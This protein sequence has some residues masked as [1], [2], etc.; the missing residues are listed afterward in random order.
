MKFVNVPASV[1]AAYAAVPRVSSRISSGILRALVL[2][3][4][5]AAA[6]LASAQVQRTFVNLGFEQPSAGS[7][8]C[9][10]QVADAQVPGWT[11]NHPSQAGASCAPSIAAQTGPL[12]EIWANTFNGVNAR[13]GTQFAELNAEAASRIYQNVCLAAGEPIDWRFSHR[14]RQSATTNDVTEFRVGSSTGT[15]RVVRAGTQSDGG[16]GVVTCYA[17]DGGVNTNTCTSALATFGW[18]DYSGHFTWQGSTGVQAI[19]FEAVSAAG[20]ATIGNFIDDIQVTLRPFVELSTASVSLRENATSGWPMLRVVGTVPAGGIVVP[21]TVQG[22]GTAVRGSDFATTGGSDTF[23]VTIPAGVYDGNSVALPLA[24]I[25]DTLIEDNEFVDIA[26]TASPT[27]YVLSSTQV[28]GAAAILSARVTLLDNDV[29]LGV[30]LDAP[31]SVRDGAALTYTATY[32]NRT[33]RATAGDA[34]A[35][36]ATVSVSSTT[37]AGLTI[38]GWTCAASGGARCPGGAPNASVTGSGP[39]AGALLLPG[40]AGAAGGEVTFTVGATVTPNHCSAIGLSASLAAPTGFSEA[41]GAQPGFTTPAPN[42]SSDNTASR[43][44]SVTCNSAPV[45]QAASV[46]VTNTTTVAITLGAIDADGD[47]L[48]Y[49]VTTPPAHGTL[50][51]TAPALTYTPASGYVGSDTFAFTANDGTATSAPATISV[52]VTAA[53]RAPAFTG[54]APTSVDEGATYTFANPV[55]DPDS[56]DTQNHSRLNGPDDLAVSASTGAIGWPANAAIVGSNRAPNT[57]CYGGGTTVSAVPLMADV[58]AIVDESG[59]MIGEHA[60]TAD[61]AIPFHAYLTANGIGAGGDAN[62]YGLMG[63]NEAPRVIPVGG[64]LMGNHLDFLE[65][66]SHYVIPEFGGTEDGW[67]AIHGALMQYPLRENSSR[68]V[69]LITDEDRD[70]ANVSLS[71]AS[72]LAELQTYK[73]ALTAVVNARFQCGDASVALGLGPDGLG[74]KA[75]GGGGY[76]TCTNASAVSGDG[77]TIADYVNLALATG[78]TAWDIELLRDGGHMAESFTSAL[79]AA[80]VREILT[81]EPTAAQAD[82]YVHDLRLVEGANDVEVIIG[83]RGLAAVTQAFTV[84]FAADGNPF[85]QVDVASLANG[86]TVTRRVPWTGGNPAQISATIS[87]PGTIDC[88]ADNASL[89]AVVARV[90]VTDAGGLADERQFSIGVADVNAA[91]SIGSTAP[92]GVVPGDRYVYAVQA[93]DPDRGDALEYTLTTAPSGMTIDRLTG[94]I[95]FAPTSNQSGSHAVTV[96]VADLAGLYATQSYSLSVGAGRVLPRFTSLPNRRAVQGQTYTYAPTVSAAPDAVLSFTRVEGPSGMQVDAT[97]GAVSWGVPGDFAGKSARVALRVNDQFGGFHLQFFTLLGDK[98]NEPPVFT[99]QPPT[100]I[101][102][103]GD[104]V[105]PTRSS[106]INL[107]ET[108]TWSAPLKPTGAA[109]TTTPANPAPGTWGRLTWPLTSQTPVAP[110]GLDLQNPWCSIVPASVRAFQP[111]V[112]WRQS[113]NGTSSQPLVGPLTDTDG[114]GVLNTNDR[115]AAVSVAGLGGPRLRAHDAYTGDILWTYTGG[116]ADYEV[117]PAMADLEGRGQVTILYLDTTRRLVALNGDGTLRWTSS[118]QAGNY[119]FYTNAISLADLDRD[120][121]AEILIGPAVFSANGTLRWQYPSPTY[122]YSRAVALDLDGDGVQEVL[123]RSEARSATGT[124][125]W[126]TPSALANETVQHSQLAP[127]PV[128]GGAQLGVVVSEQTTAGYRLSLLRSDGTAIWRLT[129]QTI[130]DRVGAPLVADFIAEEPGYEIY[131]AAMEKL[132]SSQD[133]RVIWSLKGTQGARRYSGATAAALDGDNDGFLEIYSPSWDGLNRVDARTGV[134]TARVGSYSYQFQ[135]AGPVPTFADPRGDGQGRLWLGEGGYAA[136]FTPAIGNWA[137]GARVVHQQAYAADRIGEDMR[138]RVAMPG[139]LPA[140]L[141]VYGAPNPA[142]TPTQYQSDLRAFGPYIQGTSGEITLRADVRNRGTLASQPYA[143]AFYRG[144]SAIQA[145]RIGRVELPAL[146]VGTT[147][148]ASLPGLEPSALGSGPLFAAIEPASNENECA[149]GNNT[150]GGWAFQVA[151]TDNEAATTTQTWAAGFVQA[152]GVAP[153]FTTTGPTTGNEQQPYRYD[154]VAT[155]PYAGDA[156]TYELAFGPPGMV[157]D[158]RRGTVEWTPAWGQTGWWQFTIRATNLAGSYTQQQTWVNVTPSSAPNTAPAFTSTAP[159]SAIVGVTYDY[160][161]QAADAEGHVIT[162]ALNTAPTGMTIEAATGRVRWTPSATATN[163]PVTVKATDARGA[164][165]TQS[166]TLN[167]YPGANRAPVITSTPGYTAAPASAYAYTVTATDADNDTLTTTWLTV[168]GG[169]TTT[170]ATVNW[171]PQTAQVGEHTF[172]LEV[173]DGRGG[174]AS[175][176]WVVFV[177]DAATNG[178]PSLSGTPGTNATIAQSYTYAPSATDPDNDTLAWRLAR[179]PAGMTIS[180]STGAIAWTPVRAQVGTHAV[181]IE[182]SDGHGGGAWQDY[183]ITAAIDPQNPPPNTAPVIDSEPPTAAKIG[184]AYRYDVL[185]HDDDGETLY[186]S[187]QQ[188]PAGMTIASGTGRID[189][190]AA[191]TGTVEV[192]VRVADTAGSWAEQSWELT[193]GESGAMS[194]NLLVAPNVVLPNQNVNVKLVPLRDAGPLTGTLTLDGQAVALDAELEAVV[195]AAAPGYHTLSASLNDGVETAVAAAQFFVLDPSQA[196]APRV[197]LTAPEDTA[198]ITRPT[199]IRGSI[200]DADLANWTLTLT[201]T[202]GGAPVTL[203]SGTTTQVDAELGTLDP[204]LRLNGQYRLML[205][206]TDAAGH[207]SRAT[208]TVLIDGEMKVGHF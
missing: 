95:R 187:L 167:V 176:S 116:Y 155:S 109:L 170:G 102:G 183:T 40:G 54:E 112:A 72:V 61:F 200:Q 12:I 70:A 53:N 114:N 51:G 146:P 94:V 87:A 25:D 199:A 18:R 38:H 20:G 85:A 164:F 159:T 105:Y 37:P 97:S 202:N 35:H 14:G 92:T 63:F 181:R 139:V 163:V 153:T 172:A 45:A 65:A 148:T 49:T 157:V 115:I 161:A 136:S 180:A 190:A 67:N 30:A 147:A 11:T 207:L 162:Y 168:P 47:A 179:A 132:F 111:A 151:V 21:L 106:D 26:I 177:N 182:V 52:T 192:R 108:Q 185:A 64:L 120:G 16:G 133:G 184:R 141:Y 5:L 75:D 7:S 55:S 143:V 169:A 79:I 91:P 4:G 96:K 104:Y 22:S 48:T 24:A 135:Y 166:F 29:D 103:T 6:P 100:T 76:V 201:D 74:Y 50:S 17:N 83:N 208:R 197:D 39:I 158:S 142:V 60:W 110:A 206:A 69:M 189:W 117:A 152:T 59:S 122:E 121:V 8:T 175:Q 62:R 73:I 149:T 127:I 128:A 41:T 36:D 90:G 13:A 19:G 173:R 156:V 125:R 191:Q 82:L 174:I 137:I 196:D 71:Y 15:N 144:T 205:E 78:G 77:T 126:K 1:G 131:S 27:N 86:A 203:A 10:F 84:A 188:A 107:F 145:N 194:L 58:I 113:S 81:Q 98:P 118:A 34:T 42:G 130:V 89:A 80:Q 123:Y 186:Y 31:A 57:L 88:R 160:A 56:G 204:T 198:R 46:S 68:Q 154:A 66:T 195:T 28:C 32:R 101:T 119:A 33:A 2:A 43:S 178:A 124:L 193:V 140:P 165:V 129:D 138:V 134:V 3:A 150:S 9:Y 44:V 23:S 93:T 171:T 99:T